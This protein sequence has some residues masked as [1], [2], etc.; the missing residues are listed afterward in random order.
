MSVIGAHELLS[1]SV[2]AVVWLSTQFYILWHLKFI[3]SY[4]SFIRIYIYT[5][6]YCPQEQPHKMC[7]NFKAFN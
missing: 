7:H 1:V 4:P 6:V 3:Q 5:Y 2:V